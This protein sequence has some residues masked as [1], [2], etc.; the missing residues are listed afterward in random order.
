MESRVG[1]NNNGDDDNDDDIDD[2]YNLAHYDSDEDLEGNPRNNR[3]IPFP[4][5]CNLCAI[6]SCLKSK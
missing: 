6:R 3:C 2:L 5:K 1:D 4:G